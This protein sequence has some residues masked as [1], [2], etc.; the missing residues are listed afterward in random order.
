MKGC[1]AAAVGVMIGVAGCGGAGGSAPD[2]SA[3]PATTTTAPRTSTTTAT[4]PSSGRLTLDPAA[5][6]PAGPYRHD[7]TAASFTVPQPAAGAQ[8]YGSA[9]ATSWSVRQ[10]TDPCDGCEPGHVA[11][12]LV[13]GSVDD[14][15][16]EW[17]TATGA[18]LETPKPV[19]LGGA[20]GVRLEGSVS[21]TSGVTVVH[22]GYNP[23]GLV[24]V[25]ILSTAKGTCVVTVDQYRVEAPFREVGE[26]LVAT[27]A[28]DA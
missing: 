19:T 18:E 28:F 20:R 12:Q 16:K 7:G 22:G 5:V 3:P 25:H 1:V 9:D 6:V 11:V 2:E 17:L 13:P 8:W 10:A 27:L 15:A 4:A 21:P 24:L 14:A 23:I 26:A